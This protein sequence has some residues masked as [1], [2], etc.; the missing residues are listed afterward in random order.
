MVD[1]ASSI[2]LSS[3]DK[4]RAA[5]SEFSLDVADFFPY[6]DMGDMVLSHRGAALVQIHAVAS[7]IA[8]DKPTMTFS[9]HP[10]REIAPS[11]PYGENGVLNSFFVH[12]SY[13][14]D[15]YHRRHEWIMEEVRFELGK[16]SRDLGLTPAEDIL[17]DRQLRAIMNR[18]AA[19]VLPEE[20]RKAGFDSLDN[21]MVYNDRARDLVRYARRLRESQNEDVLEMRF[22]VEECLHLTDQ[23]PGDHDARQISGI[24]NWYAG[25][26]VDE[27]LQPAIERARLAMASNQPS[28]VGP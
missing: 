1:S 22:F 14:D 4:I 8:S 23:E 10:V 5:A 18:V 21:G 9:L 17:T 25:M 27:R 20:V 24:A 3:L 11:F 12:T 2:W 26:E 6:P 13:E 16:I 19:F 28:P 15:M 7:N